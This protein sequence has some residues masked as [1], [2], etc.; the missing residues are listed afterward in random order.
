MTRAALVTVGLAA[1][2]VS[3]A[4]AAAPARSV[5]ARLEYVAEAGCPDEKLA[6]RLAPLVDTRGSAWSA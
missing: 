5:E 4:V 6:P 1:L 3:R 2:S